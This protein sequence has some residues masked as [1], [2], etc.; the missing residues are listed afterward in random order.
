MPHLGPDGKA[1]YFS[2]ARDDGFGGLDM[3]VSYLDHGDFQKPGFFKLTDGAALACGMIYVSAHDVTG[4]MAFLIM[5]AFPLI[6]V[7]MV[8]ARVNSRRAE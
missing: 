2:A 5:F 8:R 3:M 7:L 4:P 1:L 6:P